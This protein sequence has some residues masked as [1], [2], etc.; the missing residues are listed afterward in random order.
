VHESQVD[1]SQLER[2]V[3]VY[4]NN[5]RHA[6]HVD[7]DPDEYLDKDDLVE[8]P[9]RYIW[10]EEMCKLENLENIFAQLNQYPK[11][12]MA[13][14]SDDPEDYE[15]E[16]QEFIKDMLYG[17]TSMSVGDAVEVDGEL[18]IVWDYGFEKYNEV[19]E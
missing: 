19:V 9:V 4:Y 5:S 10:D 15:L 8:M 7:H 14:S 16:S 2:E 13:V 12:P 3:K 1:E 17:H 11:N 18:W 6:M